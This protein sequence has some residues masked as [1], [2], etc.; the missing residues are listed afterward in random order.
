[1]TFEQRPYRL[2]VLGL[3]DGVLPAGERLGDGRGR[4]DLLVAGAAVRSERAPVGGEVDV[5]ARGNRLVRVHVSAIVQPEGVHPH[6][7][8]NELLADELEQRLPGGPGAPR[9]LCAVHDGQHRLNRCVET[10]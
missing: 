7:A 6:E 8:R 1:M 3:W 10:R 9:Y 5:V 4:A 2:R